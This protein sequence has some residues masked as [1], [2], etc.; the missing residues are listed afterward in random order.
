LSRPAVEGSAGG[1][2]G[3]RRALLYGRVS[4][5]RQAA[6]GGGLEVQLDACRQWARAGG[7]RVAG[8]FVDEGVSG[9]IDALPGRLGLWDAIAELR[10][11]PG[12]VVVVYRLDRL[13][14]DLV[15]QEQLLADV[16][17]AGG[18]L[19]STSAAEDAHLVDD[20]AD[21][22]R[23]L[24]RQVLGAVAEH[25]RAVIRLRMAA[26]ADRKRAAG[27]YIGGRPPYGRR[28]RAGALERDPAAAGALA[29]IRRLAREDASLR[30]IVGELEAAGLAAPAGRRWH[31]M[32]VARILERDTR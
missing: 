16:R 31:P 18:E 11:R 32:T 24:V 8:S 5:E 22:T 20:P 4:T 6:E 13:A 26:G 29:L 7:L 17:R 25:E 19:H 1:S 23:R 14:R 12:A 2:A 27:G 3:R 30:A 21:P 15:L 10:R 9:S 28:A